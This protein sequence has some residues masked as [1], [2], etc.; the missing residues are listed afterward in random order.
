MASYYP[1]IVCKGVND[2]KVLPKEGEAWHHEASS[3][4]Q[5]GI[6]K[7]L[8]GKWPLVTHSMEIAQMAVEF[9]RCKKLVC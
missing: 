6:Q 2:V 3:V 4:W 9:V 7:A 8:N 1:F 5:H